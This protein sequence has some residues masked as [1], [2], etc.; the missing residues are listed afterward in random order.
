MK[1]ADFIREID[2]ELADFLDEE[3]KDVPECRYPTST[4]YI[5]TQEELKEFTDEELTD[6]LMDASADADMAYNTADFDTL[7]KRYEIIRDLITEE[8]AM[9]GNEVHI[10]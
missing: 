2:P 5:P 9:R 3:L 8:R 10:S 7:N 4:G 1:A 6:L